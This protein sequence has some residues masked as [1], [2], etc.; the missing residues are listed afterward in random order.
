ME[1]KEKKCKPKIW[2]ILNT[3]DGYQWKKV[4]M[5]FTIHRIL[6]ILLAKFQQGL[7]NLHH[8]LLSTL[9]LA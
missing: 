7:E 1:F 2:H 4:A 6:K 9:H 3:E 5:Y 8:A